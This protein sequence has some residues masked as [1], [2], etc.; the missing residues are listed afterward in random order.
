M[1]VHLIISL[2]ETGLNEER[3][4][5]CEPGDKTKLLS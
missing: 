3:T 2:R 5:L 1:F 4:L